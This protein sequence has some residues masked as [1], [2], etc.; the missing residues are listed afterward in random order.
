[1]GGKE[2]ENWELFHKEEERNRVELEKS[3]GSI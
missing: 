2:M 3:M 1:M